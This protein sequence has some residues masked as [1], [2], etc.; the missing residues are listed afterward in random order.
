[1]QPHGRTFIR[2]ATR[3]GNR[4]QSLYKISCR[5]CGNTDTIPIG[6]H[7]GSLPPEVIS[8]K[9]MQRGWN[10]G[11]RIRDDMCPAC[12]EGLKHK[13]KERNEDNVIMLPELPKELP[14]GPIKLGDLKEIVTMAPLKADPPPVMTK[15][16]RRIIFAGIDEHYVDEST[17][18]KPGW[19]DQKIAADLNVPL[20]WVRTIR[21]DNFGPEV[22]DAI[23]QEIK[24]LQSVVESAVQLEG[25]IIDLLVATTE[26]LTAFA[27]MHDDL[28]LQ[29]KNLRETITKTQERIT[30]WKK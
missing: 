8:K 2:S 30:Q 17:G 6:T 14:S 13:K 9:F 7:S 4:T 24:K 11:H 22:G 20:A 10:V 28:E 27:K 19:S 1:M 3:I 15:E 25:K 18:Y 26:K 16:D 23:N 5:K 29:A 21:E 12:V